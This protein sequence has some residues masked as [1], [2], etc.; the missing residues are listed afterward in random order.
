MPEPPWG[1]LPK[2]LVI[3]A[4]CSSDFLQVPRERQIRRAEACSGE[5]VGG[6]N[7]LL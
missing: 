3:F 4:K 2:I 6:V 5:N 7:N 1:V